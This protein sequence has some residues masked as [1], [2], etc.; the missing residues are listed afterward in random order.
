M[1]KDLF[2]PPP[3]PPVVWGPDG[4]P[5]SPLFGD[6]YRSQGQD[7]Q[8]GLAQSRHV[9]LQGCHLHGSDAAWRNHDHWTVLETGFGL[10]LNFLATWLAWRSDPQRP[11]HLHFVSVEAYPVTAHDLLKSVQPWPELSPLAEELAKQ[12]WGLTPGLHRL[13]FDEGQVHLTLSIGLAE[14]R[15]PLL[16]ARVDSV[17]LDGFSPDLNPAM[18]SAATLAAIASRCRPGARLATWTV[19]RSVREALSRQGFEVERVVGLAPKRHALVA[20]Y[21]PDSSQSVRASLPAASSPKHCLVLGAGLAGAAT[22]RALAERGWRVTVLDSADRCAAGASGLPAGLCAPHVSA[23]DKPLSRLSRAGVRA[24]WAQVQRLLTLDVDY[25]ASGVLER[26]LPGKSRKADLPSDW[27]QA[28]CEWTRYAGAAEMASVG[29]PERAQDH[30]AAL[31]HPSGFW[32]K[33]ERLVAALLDHPGIELRLRHSV[34]HLRYLQ[35]E[36]GW[37]A[38]LSHGK[39]MPSYPHIVLCTGPA[40]TSLLQGAVE[41]KSIPPLTPV[42]GQLSWGHMTDTLTEIAPRVAVNGDGSFIAHVPH[43][44]RS[45]W[46]AGSSF[47]RHRDQ[48]ELIHEDHLGNMERLRRLLA[49]VAVEL[50]PALASGQIQ[51]WSA[52][53][54]TTPDRLPRVGLLDHKAAPGLHLLTGLGARGLT[55]SVLSGELLA[56]QMN[57]EPWPIETELARLI[58]ADRPFH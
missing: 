39:L 52:V 20:T 48:P 49:H 13:R 34:Q 24:T 29:L 33:P 36:A 53:R 21:R 4:T 7:G 46:M 25:A 23:D 28:G 41:T 16:H 19:A 18:W 5:R 10:G 37:Q 12:W 45:I 1:P 56:S 11:R 47:D 6:I 8:G 27:T 9:F 38:E 26:R 32:L 51:G 40:T 31:W 30:P 42:R 22:A 35:G 14:E 58:A 3:E 54:C 43:L 17:F 44:G 50:Q 55:L 15:L 57:G 2:P